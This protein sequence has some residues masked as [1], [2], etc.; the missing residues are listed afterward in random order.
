MIF[1]STTFIASSS[2]L[3]MWKSS[4]ATAV[5]QALG[6]YPVTA[7]APGV[8]ISS[9]VNSGNSKQPAEYTLGMDVY[10]ACDDLAISTT[11]VSAAI[12]ASSYQNAK[13][14]WTKLSA[15]AHNTSS[16]FYNFKDVSDVT[17]ISGSTSLVLNSTDWDV[18]PGDEIADDTSGSFSASG[19][20]LSILVV[21]FIAAFLLE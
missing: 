2:K 11:A 21:A 14:L 6:V 16:V 9:F 4:F 20:L 5:D 15:L 17:G 13:S 3:A 7:S 8:N 19:S 1:S 12:S 18:Y 10:G